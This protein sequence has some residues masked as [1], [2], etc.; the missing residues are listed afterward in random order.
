MSEK[1]EK[2]LLSINLKIIVTS[3]HTPQNPVF[4]PL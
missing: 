4:K 1:L 3:L 2:L